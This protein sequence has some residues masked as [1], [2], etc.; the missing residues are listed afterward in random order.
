MRTFTFSDAKSYKFWNI[1]VSGTSFTVT[2]GR[3]G[4]NGQTQTKTFPIPEKTQAEA[5]KLIKEKTGK[6]YVETTVLTTTGDDAT[7]MSPTVELLEAAIMRNSDDI[8]AHAA[9]GDYLTEIGDPR[10]ELVQV[11]L[12]LEDTS[13]TPAQRKTLEAVEKQILVDHQKAWFGPLGEYL[14]DQRDVGEYLRKA[15]VQNRYR[16]RRGWLDSVSF[17]QP[18][19]RAMRVLSRAPIARMLSELIVNDDNYEDGYTGEN[20]DV[21]QPGIDDLPEDAEEG[22]YTL[23]GLLQASFLPM[24]RKLQCGDAVEE[25]YDDY[26]SFNC[27]FSGQVIH[28]LVERLPKIEEL[29]LFAHNIDTAKLFSFKNLTNLRLLQV[30]H[31]VSYPV[32]RLANNP[33]LTNLETLL[34]HPHALEDEP[35]LTVDGLEAI[36]KSKYLKNL[37]HLR[38]RLSDA[39][40]DGCRTIV[41]TGLLKRLTTLD[42]RHGRVTDAGLDVLLASPD[43]SKLER[44]DLSRNRLTPAGI[45]KLVATGVACETAH[46]GNIPTSEDGYEQNEYLYA[47]DI[48]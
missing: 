23:Y 33:A 7:E 24:L 21:P 27:H 30:Y 38:Y 2:Y 26:A 4:A 32:E 5:D 10:G 34:L 18:S 46:Q 22:Q 44:I 13:R 28:K 31:S 17:A 41:S 12:A 6:G 35:M 43:F 25:N 20:G 47:G 11:Q 8:A 36:G 45:A 1:E 14:I 16:L 29:R 15:G 48:E 42:L 39:G 3:V 9:Y 19:L 37:K 40:D